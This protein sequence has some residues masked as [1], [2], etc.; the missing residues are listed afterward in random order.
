[1][2]EIT[3]EPQ[4]RHNIGEQTLKV[5]TGIQSVRTPDGSVLFDA[6]RGRILTLNAA[7]SEILELLRQGFSLSRIAGKISETFAL[8]IPEAEADAL[9]FVERLQELNILEPGRHIGAS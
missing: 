5:C 4:G 2:S 3:I 6:R 7:G 8:P 1:M 9:V